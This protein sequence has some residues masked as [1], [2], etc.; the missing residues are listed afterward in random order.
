M[1]LLRIAW[2][3]SPPFCISDNFTNIHLQLIRPIIPLV[4]LVGTC[5]MVELHKR[6]CRIIR[7]VWKY[8][9]SVLKKI[10]FRPVDGSA[11]IHT[12]ASFI[13]LSVYNLNFAVVSAGIS[14]PVYQMDWT[15]EHVVLFDP[16]LVWFSH[17]HLIYLFNVCLIP[18]PGDPTFVTTHG[19][20]Y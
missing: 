6:N 11:V 19:V 20:S 7:F 1:W 4:V 3:F 2:K 5:I 17:M 9:R 10:S 12:F 13:F 8:L 15:E 14:S 18:I 16:T